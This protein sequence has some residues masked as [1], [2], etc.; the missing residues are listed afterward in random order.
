[1]SV[2][3]GESSGAGNNN[4]NTLKRV[5]TGVYETAQIGVEYYSPDQHG[6]IYGTVYRQYHGAKTNGQTIT[7]TGIT[8]LVSFGG[9]FNSDTC[10]FGFA[11]DGVSRI[12]LTRITN[13][14]RCDVTG[15]NIT[16]GW[17]DYTK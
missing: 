2:F 8:N 7:T 11:G 1:M 4:N 9:T 3:I 5:D 12:T 13:A 10:Y 15:W 6:G 16:T 17:V 14:V